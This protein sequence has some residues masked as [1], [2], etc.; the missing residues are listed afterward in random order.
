MDHLNKILEM[1]MKLDITTASMQLTFLLS[2]HYKFIENNNEELLQKILEHLP[3]AINTYIDTQNDDKLLYMLRTLA[4][5]NKFYN[6]I[7]NFIENNDLYGV[8]RV[9]IDYNNNVS[10]SLCWL[11]GNLY[12]FC[13]NKELLCKLY[14]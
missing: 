10:E 2:C 13:D 11:L 6:N 4:N 1:I 7:L 12:N 5:M 8:F 3:R 14:S 9:L